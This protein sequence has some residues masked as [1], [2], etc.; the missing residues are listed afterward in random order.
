M[1]S[2]IA[3]TIKCLILSGLI[4]AGCTI[5]ETIDFNLD[6]SGTRTVE[7]QYRA[8]S[9]DGSK[10]N[11]DNPVPYGLRYIDS[12]S[13]YV[14]NVSNFTIDTSD[15]EMA[16]VSYDFTAAG[17]QIKDLEKYNYFIHKMPE[18]LQWYFKD[19]PNTFNAINKNQ[20]LWNAVQK[21]LDGINNESLKKLSDD[22]DGITSITKLNFERTIKEI[23]PQLEEIFISLDRKSI[24]ADI[25]MDDVYKL[26]RANEVIITF[27]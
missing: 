5:A 3:L 1:K 19:R 18:E 24:T 27:D 8:L 11:R 22:H 15:Y 23:Q 7:F 14:D 26:K 21:N 6:F 4:I 12:I 20:V 13:N 25:K 9:E 2:T 17:P 10:S 16:K